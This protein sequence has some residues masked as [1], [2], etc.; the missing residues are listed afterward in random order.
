MQKLVKIGT[1]ASLLAMAQSN[2][3]KNSIEK[4]YSDVTV[5]LVKI[6]TKGDKILDVP[7][8]KVGGKGLFVK[9]IEEALLR[10]EVDI[11]VHS[12][13][14][15]PSELPDELH[16]GIIT[17]R[18]DPRDAF[19]SNHYLFMEDL[20]QGAKVGTSSLR[21]KSQLAA[22]RPD[23]VIKDLRGNLDTRLRKLDEGMYHAIILAAAGL[24]RLGLSD[25]AMSCFAPDIMLPAVGQGAVG[26][27]LRKED[28]ELLKGLSFLDDRD[29]AVAVTAERGFLKRLEGGC[30]VP[31][32]AFAEIENG[33]VT[34]TGLVAEVD[35][36]KVIRESVSGSMTDAESLGRN[37]AEEILKLGGEK[38]LA[39]VYD[40]QGNNGNGK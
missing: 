2:W 30:Q 15:V 21:R 13:K 1:R 29:T 28:E 24:N 7:L 5:E 31:I 20:P 11:A 34:L 8:A 32:G 9:E 19:V 33:R 23:L 22:L 6:V 3:V 26:I 16:L 12:M 38:I 4:Q 35:G 14:D 17:K 25:R 36:G 37:L 39:E 10:K 27:E 40:T 18:E